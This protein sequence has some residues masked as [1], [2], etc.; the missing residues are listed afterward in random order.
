MEIRSL[1]G[2]LLKKKTPKKIKTVSF[3]ALK[4]WNNSIQQMVIEL[5]LESQLVILS[6]KSLWC[7]DWHEMNYKKLILH[8]IIKML[9]NI[10]TL[11]KSSAMIILVI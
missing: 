3:V 5:Y 9:L 1:N 6:E 7:R 10:I 4:T 8:M 11:A 2:C